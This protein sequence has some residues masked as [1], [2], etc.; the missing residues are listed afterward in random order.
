MATPA[1]VD[2]TLPPGRSIHG[3][4]IRN[5]LGSG[6][7]SFV[8]LGVKDATQEEF[9][10]KVFPKSNLHTTDDEERFQREVDAMAYLRNDNLVAMRDFFW[11]ANNFYL[12]LDYCPGGE[13]FDYIIE[14][15]K[16]GEPI[17]ALLFKQIV[18]AIAYCHSSGVAHRDLKPENI[19]FTTFPNLKVTDFGL[20]GYISEQKLMRS[21]CGSPCYCAPECLCRVQYD[22]RLS[23]IWSMGVI[24]YAMVTG[25]QPWTVKNTSLMLRQIM[26]A[27]YE[28]PEYLSEECKS[29]IAGLL[30][31]KPNERLTMKSIIDHP[32]LKFSEWALVHEP[33]NL[34]LS[35]SQIDLVKP[36]ALDQLSSSSSRSSHMSDHG[37]VSPFDAHTD[38]GSISEDDG[39]L[40]LGDFS[41]LSLPRLTLRSTRNSSLD[42][43]PI[44]GIPH[45]R[46]K[47]P[48][49]IS[50]RGQKA[51]I[52]TPS[53]MPGMMSVIK[54]EREESA[55][56]KLPK[57]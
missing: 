26:Q 33:V 41:S 35:L 14:H 53:L 56:P 40:Q 48:M 36:M 45:R 4:T 43:I 29:L 44:R 28:I 21:F 31:L 49:P 1:I 7:F 25:Q 42:Q 17:A 18:N 27:Q 11:D 20:C 38:D 3:Y 9:A 15:R 5:K 2:V 12:I 54:E 30:K 51:R 23:D 37:I 13:L 47:A 6:T 39:R 22:G 55:L 8:F 57:A 16:L 52:W 50:S 24:L 10:I 46:R 32:W 34:D 19:L